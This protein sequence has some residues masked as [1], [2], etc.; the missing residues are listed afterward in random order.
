VLAG[1]VG[2]IDMVEQPV[3]DRFE[4]SALTRGTDIDVIAD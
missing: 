3:S 4:L 1:M 2:L